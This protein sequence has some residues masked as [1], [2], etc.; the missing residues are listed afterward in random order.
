MSGMHTKSQKEVKLYCLELSCWLKSRKGVSAPGKFRY[1]ESLKYN[2]IKTKIK[3]WVKGESKDTEDRKPRTLVLFLVSHL[4]TSGKWQHSIALVLS[5]VRLFCSPLDYSLP[6]SSVH[7]IFQ[8]RIEWVA[9]SYSRESSR[10]RDQ[11]HFSCVF[12]IG[13]QFLYH[14]CHLGSPTRL[15]GDN[16]V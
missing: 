6:D 12:C 11:T 8:A 1:I 4:G 7:G 14:Q 3:C 15:I 9:I 10:P 2:D 16:I 13:R 5:H